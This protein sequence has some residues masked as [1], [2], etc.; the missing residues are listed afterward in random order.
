MESAAECTLWGSAGQCAW[1]A[2]C[3]FVSPVYGEHG[4]LGVGL[5]SFK[6][7]VSIRRANS[8]ALLEEVGA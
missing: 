4:R 1:A 6:V 5:S 7:P 2:V 3:Q 8:R